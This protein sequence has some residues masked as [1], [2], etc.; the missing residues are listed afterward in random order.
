MD[1]FIAGKHRDR[2]SRLVLRTRTS[3]RVDTTCVFTCLAASLSLSLSGAHR[4]D[5]TVVNLYCSHLLHSPLIPHR[6][7]HTRPL[8]Y[9]TRVH[10]DIPLCKIQHKKKRHACNEARI[11][12]SSSFGQHRA[13]LSFSPSSSSSSV[14]APLLAR[15][16]FLV[17][18]LTFHH[19][20]QTTSYWCFSLLSGSFLFLLLLLLHDS[21]LPELRLAPEH[22]GEKE[23][24]FSS[25]RSARLFRDNKIW[26]IPSNQLEIL[27][28]LTPSDAEN[29]IFS[30]R[31]HRSARGILSLPANMARWPW[32]RENESEE[33]VKEILCR[34]VENEMHLQAFNWT[35]DCVELFTG[36]LSIRTQF[37]SRMDLLRKV[38]AFVSRRSW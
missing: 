5:H 28:R 10:R 20:R 18:R 26:K 15:V 23:K 32:R 35:F 29:S 36:V 34:S 33:S 38:A 24:K 16:F 11:D 30:R 14:S 22:Q 17:V 7:R 12:E 21:N 6:Q 37:I 31:A 4:Q 9:T 27:R 19:R 1:V 25:C 2:K 13:A 8:S 3:P